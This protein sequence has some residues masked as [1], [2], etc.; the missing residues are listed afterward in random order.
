MMSNTANVP[1]P[2]GPPS[3]DPDRK[4]RRRWVWPVTIAAVLIVV[5]ALLW[6]HHETT[7]KAAA[8][9]AARR[10]AGAAITITSATAQK[11][12]IGVYLDAIGTVTPVYTDSITSQV[13][14]LVVAVHYKE[15][16]LVRKGD[17][18]IDIDS[19]PYRATLLQA[20]G[21]LERDQN[22]LAQ[23]QLDLTRYRAALARNAIAEQVVADQEKLVLQDEGTVKNDQGTVQYDQL[24]VDYCHITAPIN[25]QVGL[26]LVD[27]GN[28]V[29]SSGSE[30]LSVITQLEPITV[31]FTISE[32]SLGPV[33]ARLRKKAKLTIDAYDRT[34][35]T[36]IAS[37]KLMALDN[38]IDTTTGTVKGRSVFDNKND[39]L[40]PNQFVNTRLLVN[41]LEGVTLVPESA[42]QQNGQ[43]S[44]VYVIQGNIAHKMNVKAGVTEGNVTQVEGINPGDVV[45]NSGFDK[46]Q[47]NAKVAVSTQH[48]AV[49]TSA[50]NAP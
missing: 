37:G 43:A 15:G 35:Q 17:P 27:P 47:D 18:L 41:T 36:K 46:L 11:G 50:S 20:Q 7:V 42:V 2:P 34:A 25:G 23:A 26:R 49:E 38:Q 44:F 48:A 10:A 33:A 3:D 12:N 40:F 13:N 16:Q 4:R 8:A 6:M 14:G 24:Q 39:A 19:R 32:D 21:T 5:G 28:V 45:A 9:A 1:K 29:Q 30:T 31:I 22:V